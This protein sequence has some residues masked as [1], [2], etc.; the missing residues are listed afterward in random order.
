MGAGYIYVLTNPSFPAYVKIGY[1][2]D[3]EARLKELNKSECLPFA[4]RL[5][6][7]LEVPKRLADKDAQALIDKLYPSQQAVETFDGKPRVR[8]FFSMSA[9]DAYDVLFS[10]AAVNGALG[11]LKLY[12]AGKSRLEDEDRAL[13]AGASREVQAAW[14]ALKQRVL[15]L[16]DVALSFGRNYAFFSAGCRRF[17]ACEPQKKHLALYLAVPAG[18]LD[19]P[20]GLAV[21]MLCASPCG[22]GE[23]KAFAENAAGAEALMPLVRQAFDGV[24]TMPPKPEPKSGEALRLRFWEAFCAHAAGKAEMAAAFSFRKPCAQSF[25][26]LDIGVSSLWISLSFSARKKCVQAALYFHDCK[27]LFGAFRAREGE[28]FNVLAPD[29]GEVI[30]REDVKDCRLYVQRGIKPEDESSWGA[31]F[32]WLC[33]MSLRLKGLALKYGRSAQGEPAGTSGD[34]SGDVA[35]EEAGGEET[36]TGEEAWLLSPEEERELFA[37]CM[38][39]PSL[40]MEAEDDSQRIF[41]EMR[42]AVTQEGKGAAPDGVEGSGAQEAMEPVKPAFPEE[43]PAA[44]LYARLEDAVLAFGGVRIEVLSKYVFFSVDGKLFLSVDCFEPEKLRLYL[45]MKKNDLDDPAGLA[46]DVA[47]EHEPGACRIDASS[48]VDV[49]A[50]L[51][52][53][54]Q[55]YEAAK[56]RRKSFRLLTDFLPRLQGADFGTWVHRPGQMPFVR[57]AAISDELRWAISDFGKERRDLG[58]NDYLGVLER[59]GVNMDR[60]DVSSLGGQAVAALVFCALRADRFCDGAFLGC[61]EDGRMAKW[62]ARLKEIDDAEAGTSGSGQAAEAEGAVAGAATGRP[63][64]SSM[65]EAGGE[66]GAL[67]AFI[68]KLQRLQELE[69]GTEEGGSIAGEFLGAFGRFIAGHKDRAFLDYFRVLEEA[70]LLKED[71]RRRWGDEAFVSSLGDAQVMAL[72]IFCIRAEYHSSGGAMLEHALRD[73]PIVTWLKRLRKIDEAGHA[74]TRTGAFS[75]ASSPDLEPLMETILLGLAVGDALGVPFEFMKRGTF[76][77]K[78]LLGGGGHGQPAGTWSDDTALALALADALLPGGFDAEQAGQNFQD[79][80]YK[81]KFTARG[82]VFD[83]GGAT[84]A[85]IGR[86]RH[87]VVPEQAGGKGEYDNGNGSLMRIAPI[88]PALLDVKDPEARFKAVRRASSLTHAHPLACACC[89]VFEEFLRLLSLGWDRDTGYRRLCD[90][91]ANG[92]PFI[93]GKVLAKLGRVLDGGLRYVP[94]PAIQSGGFVVHTLE[95][96]LWCLLNSESY[97]E[98]VLKAASLGR[99]AD[100]TACVAGAAAALCW[101]RDSIPEAWIEG[102]AG[103]DELL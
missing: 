3:V 22:V 58:L 69:P 45:R 1:A 8:E 42:S 80:L 32:D 26:E 15:A 63:A 39:A 40:V 51:P 94:E 75:V 31:A 61:L 103:R 62:L 24:Q 38:E 100:T 33:A 23:Y 28:V 88:V 14:T 49:D 21:L 89:F 11:R 17:L 50:A 20:D 91:F 79:W 5:H 27:E 98:T 2:D 77:A 73:A 30:W 59:A 64:E 13:F 86:M 81:G 37:P 76:E 56:A 71:A 60:S 102:L 43:A 99:D 46:V 44:A 47:E 90:D 18:A 96:A 29:A 93:E 87:G 16:D 4:F 35:V 92:F 74:K 70:G 9:E 53:V 25:Y 54:R 65:P 48:G 34:S 7:T 85:A 101:G 66:Y 36:G 82:N 19:D 83:V 95:A 55:S 57:Y 41:E 52:L 78:P 97:A 68:P 84:R 72:I 67:T 6:C 12:A 10:I